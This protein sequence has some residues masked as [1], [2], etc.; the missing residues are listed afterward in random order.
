MAVTF[1]YYTGC[2]TEGEVTSYV[3][4]VDI[5]FSSDFRWNFGEG[6]PTGNENDFQGT[7]TH[8]LG[9]AHNL[10]HV[11]APENLMHFQTDSGITSA[12]R[13]IDEDSKIAAI[14]SYDFSKEPGLC[15]QKVVSDRECGDGD[16][17]DITTPEFADDEIRIIIGEDD[18]LKVLNSKSLAALTIYLSLIH[19]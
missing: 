13:N 12:T 3:E 1:T 8:E 15:D 19:I 9:H 7:A 18:T 6:D 11:I 14:I 16:I 17:L 10:G 4:E 2:I 5:T